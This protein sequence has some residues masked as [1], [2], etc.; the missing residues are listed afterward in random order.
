MYDVHTTV[1]FLTMKLEFFTMRLDF[2]SMELLASSV[3]TTI[4][5]SLSSKL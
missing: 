5:L 2:L 4:K 3:V 1:D